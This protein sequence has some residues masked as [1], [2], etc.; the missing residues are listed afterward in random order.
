MLCLTVWMG[1]SGVLWGRRRARG[2]RS[3]RGLHRDARF[4]S[5]ALELE[6]V[7]A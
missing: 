3:H 2:R 4:I 6:L 5:L 1:S 7:C